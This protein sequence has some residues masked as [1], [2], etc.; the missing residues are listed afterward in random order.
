MSPPEIGVLQVSIK[1]DAGKNTGIPRLHYRKERGNRVADGD[2][3]ARREGRVPG[4]GGE[5]SSG[6][7]SGH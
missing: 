3:S 5:G 2:G 1:G 6:Y 7:S 4:E